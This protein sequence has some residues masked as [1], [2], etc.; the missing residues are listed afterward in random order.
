MDKYVDSGLNESGEAE[1]SINSLSLM[2]LHFLKNI[3][4]NAKDNYMNILKNE[5]LPSDTEHE[6]RYRINK[7]ESFIKIIDN[8]FIINKYSQP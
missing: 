1:Y 5:T 8:V 3:F 4:L 6:I 7:I 2:D